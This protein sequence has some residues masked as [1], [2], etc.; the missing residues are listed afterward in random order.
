MAGCMAQVTE[1]LE[2][3][4]LRDVSRCLTTRAFLAMRRSLNL[5]LMENQFSVVTKV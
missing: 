4:A 1:N 3:E 5:I 2:G